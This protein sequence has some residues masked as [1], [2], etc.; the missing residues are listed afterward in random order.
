MTM[1]VN[2][3]AATLSGIL[4]IAGAGKPVAPPSLQSLLNRG[5]E[6]I[7]EGRLMGA[8]ECAPEMAP[9]TREEIESRDGRNCI[10]GKVT[11]GSYKRLKGDNG[12]FVCV[13]FGDWACYPSPDQ[14]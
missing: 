13:S 10:F 9:I 8:V 3:M 5:F 4:T 1:A 6:V 7:V 11:Y 2:T 12:E 14:N